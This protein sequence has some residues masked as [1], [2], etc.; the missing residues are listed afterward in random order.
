MDSYDRKL[1]DLIANIRKMSRMFDELMKAIMAGDDDDTYADSWDEHFDQ[2]NKLAPLSAAATP[3]SRLRTREDLVEF[4]RQHAENQ[5][6]YGQAKEQFSR[7]R[8]KL[9]GTQDVID[10]VREQERAKQNGNQS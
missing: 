7:P 6:P 10:F 3:Y 9:N 8:R 5:T 2:H 1:D 4:V